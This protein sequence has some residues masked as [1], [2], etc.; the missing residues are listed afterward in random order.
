MVTGSSVDMLP[1]TIGNGLERHSGNLADSFT[2]LELML[3]ADHNQQFMGHE[4]GLNI[5]RSG[6]APPT[7]EGSLSAVGSLFSNPAFRDVNGITGVSSNSSN[8]GMSEDEICSHPAYLLYYYS[9]EHINPRLPPPLLS[10]ED[11]RVAQRFQAGGSSLGSIED[12]RKKKFDEGGDSSSLF[13]MQ[14]APSAQQGKNDLPKK[15]CQCKAF[16]QEDV[17]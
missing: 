3:Q 11:W 17:S 14:P 1:N 10:K 6:S 8:N 4:R 5:Y 9:H 12:W 2:E 15:E 16:A 13:S 7:E